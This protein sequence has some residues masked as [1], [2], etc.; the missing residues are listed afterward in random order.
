MAPVIKQVETSPDIPKQTTVVVIG[1]G[2]VGL[3]AALTLAEHGIPVVVLEKGRLAGEQS[4]RN[5]GSVSYTHLDVYKRQGLSGFASDFGILC[6][7]AALP[8][9]SGL[10]R[11][12]CETAQ[13]RRD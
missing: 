13:D 12:G 1:G 3:A 9:V 8:A 5:L 6:R 10:S 2:I 4:S 11:S 7:L